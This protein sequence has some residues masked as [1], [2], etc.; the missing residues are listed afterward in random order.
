[1]Q[2]FAPSLLVMALGVALAGCQDNGPQDPKVSIN[3][4]PYPSTYQ[5]LASQ[6]TLITNATVLTGTGERLDNADVFIVDGKI[7]QAGKDLSVQADKTIDTSAL[8]KRSPVP[9][10]TVA[11][12]INVLCDASG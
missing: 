6:S 11:L 7:H 8:S 12:V 9:V 4:N 1:M 2:K 3:K 5:P 10:K